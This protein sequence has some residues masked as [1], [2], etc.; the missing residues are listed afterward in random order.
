VRFELGE[1]LFTNSLHVHEF[2]GPLKASVLLAEG[3]YA[4]SCFRANT[5]KLHELSG[6]SGVEIYGSLWSAIRSRRGEPGEG[7]A[8]YGR[9][10]FDHEGLLEVTPT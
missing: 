10:R 8:E 2:F 7:Q 5:W 3:D 9:K 4:F 6:S 1:I